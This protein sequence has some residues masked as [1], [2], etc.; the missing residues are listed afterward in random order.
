M[1]ETGYHPFKWNKPDWET[2][3]SRFLP[4]VKSRGEKNYESS[5]RAIRVN[6]RNQWEE[7]GG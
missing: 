7:R 1:Y 6:E 2:K 5:Q 4:Y 3:I